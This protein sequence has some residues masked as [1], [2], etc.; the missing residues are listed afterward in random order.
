[1][2]GGENGEQGRA[3]SGAAGQMQRLLDAQN[4]PTGSAEAIAV[5]LL[6][7]QRPYRL[8]VGRRQR[9]GNALVE[10]TRTRRASV[11]FRVALTVGILISSGAIASATLLGWPRWIVEGYE[12]LV[13]PAK[14]V[15]PG[16]ERPRRKVA[17]MIAPAPAEDGAEPAALIVPPAPPPAI[18]PRPAPASAPLARRREAAA[19]AHPVRRA[20]LV[21]GED[22]SPVLAALRALRRG[23]DPVGA[24]A[25]LDAYMRQHPD[26]TLFQE[27]LAISIEAAVAHHDP[28][29]AALAA[30]YL[31]LYPTGP[32][33]ALARQTVGLP[34]GP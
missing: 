34:T 1:M 6:R 19:A 22:A 31:R 30:R 17:R 16:P 25:L 5:E 23:H 21:A 4:V 10:D 20:D 14:P 12:R 18:A 7:A 13:P 27:A 11:L 28:D 24:R 26:G 33:R 9:V 32:F 29:A 2:S 3:G 15:A 8:P